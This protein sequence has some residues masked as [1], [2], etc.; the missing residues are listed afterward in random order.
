MRVKGAG[1]EGKR[2]GYEAPFARDFW[3]M[4]GWQGPIRDR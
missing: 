4:V 2:W 3:L 1:G